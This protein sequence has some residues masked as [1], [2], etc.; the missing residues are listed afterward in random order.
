[1]IM[2]TSEHYEE[3]VLVP[4]PRSLVTEVMS[5]IVQRAGPAAIAETD[6]PDPDEWTVEQ[7]RMLIGDSRPSVQR[8]VLVLDELA[9]QPDTAVSMTEL[10]QA[11]GLSRSKLK[12]GLS[13]FTRVCKM[14]WPERD[15][16]GIWPM[17]F[18]WGAAKEPDQDGE[19]YYT[20][21]KVYAERWKQ[22]RGR[23]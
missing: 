23:R 11:T 9:K 13:G 10:V 16:H 22:A 15:T 21:R 19:A 3:L 14:L 12:G 2:P 20:L 7:F 6:E 8:I 4:V 5:L 1:M 17:R 18:S